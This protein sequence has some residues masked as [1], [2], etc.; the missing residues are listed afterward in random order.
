[1]SSL[2]LVPV[3]VV[4]LAFQR[5]GGFFEFVLILRVDQR[6]QRFEQVET[7]VPEAYDLL[8]RGVEEFNFFTREAMARSRALFKQAVELDPDY[9]RAL[10]NIALTYSTDVNFFNNPGFLIGCC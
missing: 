2:S 3:F 7:T 5:R 6:A 10:A 8:L 9:A 1:M 4:F